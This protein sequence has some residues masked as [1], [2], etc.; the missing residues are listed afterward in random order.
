MLPCVFIAAPC[1]AARVCD[2]ACVSG[3]GWMSVYLNNTYGFIQHGI[4][5]VILYA[6]YEKLLP[7]MILLDATT[8][9]D[10]SIGMREAFVQEEASFVSFSDM[11]GRIRDSGPRGAGTTRVLRQAAVSVKKANPRAR[12]VIST[13]GSAKTNPR[14]MVG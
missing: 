9:Y 2:L 13:R 12:S 7:G 6:W 5:V 11:L 1:N 8:T 14:V 10:R 4:R 3:L